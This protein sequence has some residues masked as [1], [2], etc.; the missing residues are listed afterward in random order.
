[1]QRGIRPPESVVPRRPCCRERGT[2]EGRKC[3]GR[4]CLGS[5]RRKGRQTGA[6]RKCPV[7]KVRAVENVQREEKARSVEPSEVD[8]LAKVFGYLLGLR[9]EGL[10]GFW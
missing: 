9:L 8:P 3:P 2:A 10:L 6:L 7:G 1:M 5:A 4:Q